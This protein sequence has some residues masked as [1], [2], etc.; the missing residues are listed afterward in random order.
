MP[1]RKLIGPAKDALREKLEDLKRINMIQ[2]HDHPKW[3]SPVFMVPKKSTGTWRMVIDMRYFNSQVEDDALIL[4]EIE[5]QLA[6]LPPKAKYFA[7]FDM[8]SGF[9]LLPVEKES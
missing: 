3:G 7:C 9:D 6:Y 5:S 1:H 8:L 2:Q 4:P